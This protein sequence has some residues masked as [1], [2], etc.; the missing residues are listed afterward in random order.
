[1]YM[2]NIYK[3]YQ[4]H[5]IRKNVEYKYIIFSLQ[6]IIIHL[7]YIHKNKL[8]NYLKTIKVINN[9]FFLTWKK[10]E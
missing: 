4:K 7:H 9:K 10:C 6:K 8:L 2:N 3:I 1:M 5:P